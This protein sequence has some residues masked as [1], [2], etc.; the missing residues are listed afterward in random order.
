MEKTQ[1][2]DARAM[3]SVFELLKTQLAD[4]ITLTQTTLT[5]GTKLVKA[6]FLSE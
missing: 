1:N 3:I 6:P 2:G 5:K 4:L